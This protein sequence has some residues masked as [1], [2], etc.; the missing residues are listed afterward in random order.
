MV[1]LSSI[2]QHES[3]KGVRVLPNLNPPRTLA[4][5][6]PPR[7]SQSSG[8]G[9]PASRRKVA[10]VVSLTCGHVSVLMLIPQSIPENSW[11]TELVI[12]TGE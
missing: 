8:F 7:W 12:R 5:P 11:K 9:C 6:Y 4:P 1:M 10:L 3:A 2:S